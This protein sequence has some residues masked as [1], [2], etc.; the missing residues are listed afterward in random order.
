M[1]ILKADRSY[2]RLQRLSEE[3]ERLKTELV[4]IRSMLLSL[5]ELIAE[6]IL[7]QVGDSAHSKTPTGDRGLRR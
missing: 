2:S 3:Q 5:E 7:Q 6:E 4:Q 1:R